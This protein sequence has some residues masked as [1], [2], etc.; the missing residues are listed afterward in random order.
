MVAGRRLNPSG[1]GSR[2]GT[3]P[4][5]EDGWATLRALPDV[6]RYTRQAL[7]LVWATSHRLTAALAVLTLVAGVLPAGVA[8]IGARIVDAVVT[9]IA[10]GWR[11][12]S[13]GC[14]PASRCCV[15]SSASVS[16]R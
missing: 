2:R 9:A 6:F 11:R 15:R 3:T 10:A 5:P 7:D 12:R 4:P 14:R 16:T 13:A 8:F 1:P